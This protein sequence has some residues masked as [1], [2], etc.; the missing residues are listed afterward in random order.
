[1]RASQFLDG[2]GIPTARIWQLLDRA[3]SVESLDPVYFAFLMQ[4]I[5]RLVEERRLE[6]GVPFAPTFLQ[7][8]NRLKTI[9][10]D[11][12]VPSGSWMN[13]PELR[14]KLANTFTEPTTFDSEALLNKS[15]F[16]AVKRSPLVYAGY[17]GADGKPILFEESLASP[18]L[19][20]LTGELQ[21]TEASMVFNLEP[22]GTFSAKKQPIPYTPLFRFDGKRDEIL[23]SAMKRASLTPETVAS[24]IVPPLFADLIQQNP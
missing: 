8:T 4:Q 6:W 9:L 20:G 5:S 16:D 23:K 17:V 3:S 18:Q 7:S 12:A 13:D 10:R 2:E 22:D 15:L 24:V 21:S 19:W 14:A 11:N 1:M